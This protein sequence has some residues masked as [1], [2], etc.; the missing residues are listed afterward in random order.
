MIPNHEGS[1]S[2]GAA[3]VVF[4]MAQEEGFECGF[5][6]ALFWQGQLPPFGAGRT[7][8]PLPAP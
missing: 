1:A 6:V 4:F 3:V 5:G 7:P 2:E 8:F